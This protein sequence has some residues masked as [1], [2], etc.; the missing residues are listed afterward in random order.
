MIKI[1][2]RGDIVQNS[3]KWIYDWLELEATSPKDVLDKLFNANGDEIEL[4]INSPG[5]DVYAASEIYTALKEYKGKTSCKITGIA[6]SAASIIAMGVENVMISPVAT[7]M[8]HKASVV[9][10]GNSDDLGHVVDVLDVY[11]EAISNSYALKTGMPKEKILELMKKETYFNAQQ[12][13]KLGFVDEIMFDENMKLS[14]H[15]QAQISPQV[16]NKLKSLI[17]KDAPD[18]GAFFMPDFENGAE[19]KPQPVSDKLQSQKNT[20]TKLKLKLLGGN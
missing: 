5:G 8:I 10:R 12:A 7:I 4:S 19:E 17:K 9:A 15:V 14:A 20:F 13:L 2:I 1:D 3:D 18:E 11:D 6:A 16:L